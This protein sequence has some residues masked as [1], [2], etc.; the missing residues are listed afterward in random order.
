MNERTNQESRGRVKCVVWDLD[1][2]LWK[3]VLPEGADVSLFKDSASVIRI[4]DE[5]GI[6]QSVAS[7]NDSTSALRK[8][9]D[10]GLE[11]YFL[12]PQITWS[13]KAV[14]IETIAGLLNISIDSMAFV[15]DDAA[16]L[17]EVKLAHPGVM[18]LTASKLSEI[19][20]MPEMMPLV[21]S[22]DSKVRRSLYI[23]EQNRNTA[24]ADYA[25][26]K[27]EFLAS[28]GMKLS[29]MPAERDDLKRAEELTRRTSQLNTTGVVYSYE[30]LDRLRSS[31]RHRVYMAEL[32]D[33]FGDYGKIGL[34]LI[35]CADDQWTIKLLLLSCRVITRGIG[36]VMVNCI[37]DQ[38]RRR[39]VR[40]LSEFLPNDRNRLMY[41]AYKFTGFTQID[42][43]AKLQIMEN[44]LSAPLA[45][46]PYIEIDFADR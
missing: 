24:E 25:G 46:P 40:L 20:Q 35:E 36:T 2:T 1:N 39:K 31:D 43:A 22:E 27:E 16:E 15:D 8:L 32:R 30:E 37:R 34:S 23:A 26:S 5:R 10:F 18:C 3:G 21:V 38:A 12:F 13:S 29:V 41:L 17:E 6:L 14:S 7:K 44:D 9:R 45:Y 4:L 28:L 33:R 11:D 19:P 42:T